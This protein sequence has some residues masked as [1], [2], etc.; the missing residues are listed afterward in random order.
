MLRS[1]QTSST[2][3]S[4]ALMALDP[5][6]SPK[7]AAARIRLTSSDARRQFLKSFLL[8]L[9]SRASCFS[10]D[11]KI[12]ALSRDGVCGGIIDILGYA[13]SLDA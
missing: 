2:G 10:V 6:F 8:P 5:S 3:L 4:I 11:E 1:F 9:H 12:L 7:H 13:K